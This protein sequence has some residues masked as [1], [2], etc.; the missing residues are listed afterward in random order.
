MKK[1]I[2]L[3][4]TLI[5]LIGAVSAFAL[6]AGAAT[7]PALNIDYC[8]LE[9][10]NKIHIVYAVKDDIAD[11]KVLIWTAPEAEYTADT[12]DAVI[13]DYT[14]T[15]IE[16]EAYKQFFYEELA[17]KQMTDVIYARAYS[18]S[19]GAYG[20]VN[21]YSILQYAFNMIGR[22]TTS[23]NLVV[24][25]QD[26]LAYGA[27]AQTYF[28]YNTDRL[29]SDNWYEIKVEAG[30]IDD[31]STHGL[32]LEGDT[33][34]LVAPETNE[35][36]DVFSCWK[37]GTGAEVATTATYEL[38]VGA[39][40]ETYTAI[41]VSAPPVTEPPVTEP[42]VVLDAPTISLDTVVAEDGTATLTLEIKNNPGLAVM[43]IT[44]DYD[45]E[46][47]TLTTSNIKNGDVFPTLD[48]GRNLLFSA[49]ENC[50]DDGV[51]ATL[52]FTVNE[53]VAAGEYPVTFIVRES[54]DE[55]FEP[56]ELEQIAGSIT[57]E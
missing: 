38:T 11:A 3:T 13:T 39:E 34:T 4:I 1:I 16:G 28:G 32:Y 47:L 19:T 56:V 2:T 43:T 17:A 5:L 29:A 23:E 10:D 35:A 57:V 51:L 30:L 8:N 37:N 7:E 52:K 26:M 27:S 18:E 14:T 22:E 42:P 49:D 46:A 33:V 54:I 21:K 55:N 9:F 50:Y 24:L 44:P 45:E 48:K 53:G 25:L 15:T 40:S 12:A 36:G 31:G 20:E 6:T 41:Y